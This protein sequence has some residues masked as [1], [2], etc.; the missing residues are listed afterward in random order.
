MIR[1]EEDFSQNDDEQV[2]SRNYLM[3]IDS[4][5]SKGDETSQAA[6]VTEEGETLSP[7]PSGLRGPDK[8][9]IKSKLYIMEI[10]EVLYTLS[11]THTPFLSHTE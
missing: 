8:I 2:I 11:H 5:K 4:A 9:I 6:A 3:F 10:L 1:V 7:K